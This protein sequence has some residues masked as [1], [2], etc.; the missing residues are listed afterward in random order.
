MST[1]TQAKVVEALRKMTLKACGCDPKRAI[2]EEKQVFMARIAGEAVAVKTKEARSGDPYSFLIGVFM[3]QTP[4]KTFESEALFLPGFM[5]EKIEAELKAND[6]KPVQ[7][8]YDVFARPDD[9]VTI[10]YSYVAQAVIKTQAT[11]RLEELAKSFSDKPLPGAE[12]QTDAPTGDN[13]KKK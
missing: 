10:G 3:A 9:K 8:A 1:A 5:F 12:P 6:G 11:S 7:F 4:D 2:K 13:K